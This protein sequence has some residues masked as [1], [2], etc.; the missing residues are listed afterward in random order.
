MAQKKRSTLIQSPPTLPDAHE[1]A[2]WG[3]SSSK[4][5]HSL[6]IHDNNDSLLMDGDIDMGDIS[7]DTFSEMPTPVPTQPKR[8][9]LPS[10]KLAPPSEEPTKPPMLTSRLSTRPSE[11][12]ASQPSPLSMPAFDL[13]PG[14]DISYI[15]ESN[16]SI[17]DDSERTFDEDAENTVVLSRAPISLD[18]PPLEVPVPRA[19]TPPLV[20][21]TTP[22][23]IPA[24][25]RPATPTQTPGRIEATT[26]A[27]GRRSKYRITSDTE[28][29]VAKIWSTVGDLLMPGH[30]FNTAAA[31]STNKP[32]RA[33][34][35]MCV[36]I[37]VFGGVLRYSSE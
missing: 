5:R 11:A 33:K 17:L 13:P 24:D 35:T 36:L 21:P 37:L 15:S 6:V 31:A 12:R 2:F 10:S 26:P 30:P 28:R 4:P 14:A 7:V 25:V 20:E 8:T 22:T 16:D 1:E 34:E 27:T 18:S 23:V 9:T 19:K 29:I 3:A 32:P